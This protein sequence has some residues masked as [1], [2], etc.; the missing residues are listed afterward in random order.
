M[1]STASVAPQKPPAPPPQPQKP[2]PEAQRFPGPPAE[3]TTARP[4][5]AVG[6]A[7]GASRMASR[8]RPPPA[9]SPR[10]SHVTSMR[11]LAVRFS[12]AGIGV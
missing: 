1:A 12:A 8:T 4:R 5:M 11:D 3:Q 2:A 7:A 10:R 6:C 9:A